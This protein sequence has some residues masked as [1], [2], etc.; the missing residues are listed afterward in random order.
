MNPAVPKLKIMMF[1]QYAVWGSWFVS[2]G[3]Y[4]GGALGFTGEQIGAMYATTAIAAMISPLYIGY[5]ADKMFATEKMIAALHLIGA[6]LLGA[7][8]FMT[9]FQTM[10]ATIVAYALCYMPTLALT[11]SISFANITD[12]EKEFPGI[13]VL[14]TLGWI[15]AGWV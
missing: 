5:L 14:G 8:A 9:D 3:G 1:L 2:M 4:L 6:V 11:N 12:P 13:R 7:A 10:R 15:V